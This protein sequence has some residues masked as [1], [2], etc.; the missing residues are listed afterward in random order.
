MS[1]SSNGT[2]SPCKSEVEDELLGSKPTGCVYNL[3]FLI[4]FLYSTSNRTI[5]AAYGAAGLWGRV[6]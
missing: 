6:H 5:F 2:S 3:L 1:F 4:Y